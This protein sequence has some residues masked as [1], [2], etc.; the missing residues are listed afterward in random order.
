VWHSC[1]GGSAAGTGPEPVEVG[2]TRSA[3]DRGGE[4][5]KLALLMGR[6]GKE[7][8]WARPKKEI[9]IL[10]FFQTNFIL[11]QPLEDLL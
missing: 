11:K 5:G 10:F 7:G 6:P 3:W 4:G 1:G 9:S 2:G 8:G